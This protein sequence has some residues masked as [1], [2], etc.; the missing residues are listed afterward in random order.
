MVKK[1]RTDRDSNPGTPFGCYLLSKQAPSTARPSVRYPR[2]PPCPGPSGGA[3]N[4][5]VPLFRLGRVRPFG[6][7]KRGRNVEAGL[8]FAARALGGV[9]RRNLERIASIRRVQAGRRLQRRQFLGADVILVVLLA[10]GAAAL[11]AREQ[12]EGHSTGDQHCRNTHQG[13]D[14]NRYQEF[15]VKQQS[16]EQ[17]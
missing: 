7:G 13:C 3:N 12:H 4:T 15:I 2:K 10:G 6:I 5:N 1:W 17:R 8:V 9:E 14:L 11:A 16:R